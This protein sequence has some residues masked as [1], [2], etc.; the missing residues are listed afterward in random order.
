MAQDPVANELRNSIIP[1]PCYTDQEHNYKKLLTYLRFIE[2]RMSELN[3]EITTA[4]IALNSIE[5]MVQRAES[6]SIN[7]PRSF[8]EGLAEKV[9]S[10]K[11]ILSKQFSPE[12]ML[13]MMNE[14]RDAD[15]GVTDQ[16]IVERMR[17]LERS[18]E[19]A[20]EIGGALTDVLEFTAKT[21]E[22]MIQE[23]DP[24]SRAISI[25][26]RDYDTIK[27]MMAQ[28]RS[29]TSILGTLIHEGNPEYIPSQL[30]AYETIDR[31]LDM[32]ERS[33]KKD[34]HKLHRNYSDEF[35]K[36]YYRGD[37]PRTN[38]FILNIVMNA[39]QAFQKKGHVAG[40]IYADME[41]IDGD[42]LGISISN[43]GP[44][45]DDNPFHDPHV[46]IMKA[47]WKQVRGTGLITCQ[48]I[49]ERQFGGVLWFANGDQGLVTFE[50]I[51][52]IT[53][54]DQFYKSTQNNR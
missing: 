52:P 45:L 4:E 25:T 32:V 48:D 36:V 51:L 5:T 38:T 22:S 37:V 9:E 3:S 26:E 24:E 34:G 50:A 43:D 54:Y 33:V 6:E 53:Q 41:L 30:E 10:Q 19:F 40:N 20:V 14:M 47:N 18:Y 13:A 15:I 39:V 16:N 21:T 12:Y 31:A 44:E 29:L 49:I 27:N 2:E 17:K 7:M 35:R 46:D 8:L 28:Q 42:T 1:S 11:K 23:Q